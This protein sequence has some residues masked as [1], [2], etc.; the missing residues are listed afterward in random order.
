MKKTL[1]IFLSLC[2]MLCL[3]AC[4]S[5]NS[6]EKN[7]SKEK[8]DNKYD[9][10][11]KSAI[12]DLTEHWDEE[13]DKSSVENDKYLEIK[14][15]RII[16]IKDNDIDYF[17]DVD[18][19][20]EFII[21]TDYYGSAPYYNVT[22]QYNNVVF[23]KDGSRKITSDFFRRYTSITYSTDYSDIIHSIKDFDDTYN[24]KI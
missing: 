20:V 6:G 10:I 24:R 13:F 7:K 8:N 5:D 1:S 19:V 17:K 12:A 4:G 22:T 9:K 18:Y 23:Y 14:N 11:I 21:L 2:L 15:T 16:S 3:C